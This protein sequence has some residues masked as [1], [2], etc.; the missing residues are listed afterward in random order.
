MLETFSKIGERKNLPLIPLTIPDLKALLF[1][2]QG[3]RQGLKHL[4]SQLPDT[5]CQRRTLCCSLL[6]ELSLIEALEALEQLRK[7]PPVRRRELTQKIIRYFFINP[8]EI[9]GCPFLEDRDCLIYPTRFFGCRAYGLWSKG[10]YQQSAHR[11]RLI[12]KNVVQLWRN[13]GVPL[14][15]KVTGHQV[16][17]CAAVETIGPSK[18][19]DKDLLQ[20]AGRIEGF[21]E[22]LNP[23]HL[24]FREGY[25]Q[26]LSFLTAGLF[27]DLSEAVRLKFTFVR[28]LLQTGDRN[29]LEQWVAGVPDLFDF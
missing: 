14:P 17:Y 2:S 13:L 8:L 11:A 29:P 28:D 3:Q 19:S 10:Y 9:T 5:S 21:S 27:I 12:K 25:F 18:M 23:W 7:F 24:R 6:P 4:Y 15:E 16:A 1:N 20:T 26:D 22:K